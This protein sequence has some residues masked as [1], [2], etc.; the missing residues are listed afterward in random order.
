M[1]RLLLL[2]LLST[3]VFAQK[4]SKKDYL[5][6]IETSKGTMYAVL[7]DDTPKHKANFLKLTESGFYQDLLF[8]RIV[9]E[10]MIQGGDPDSKNARKGARLGAGGSNLP[11][12]PYEFTTRHVHTKGALAA[13]RTNNPQKESSGCQFYIVTGKKYQEQQLKAIEARQVSGNTPRIELEY[14]PEQYRAYQTIGGTPF[15][16]NNYTVFGE[17]IQGIEVAETI[18]KMETDGA[19]RPLED[20]KMNISAKRMSKKK[21]SKLYGYAYAE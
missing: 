3:S 12:V 17:I 21:I 18:E 16:D 10:F 4:K 19:E 20:V 1:T 7:F 14:T 8:H 6:T 15:L 13:A 11:K 5:I 9:N 2:L